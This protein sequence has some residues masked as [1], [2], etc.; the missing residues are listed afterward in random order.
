[1]FSSALIVFREAFEIVL[2]VGI[3]LA[4]TRTLPNR[5][6]WIQLGFA[7]GI[8]GAG[9]VAYFI[10]V[11]SN[12]AE[13]VGQELFSAAILFTAAG[14]IGWTF[15]WM[16]RHAREIKT[17]FTTLGQAINEG[18][19]PSYSLSIVIALAILREGAEI[20]LF[21]Y[22]MLANGAALS[23][24]LLGSL[25]GLAAGAVVGVLFYKG[26][27]KIS[28]KHFMTITGWM[29]AL[30]VCGM[31]SQGVGKLIA[32]G[33]L[34][35]LSETAWDSSWLLSDQSALGQTLLTLV[36]YTSSPAIAQVIAYIVTLALLIGLTRVNNK[37]SQS[38]T[39]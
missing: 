36:G 38:K 2:I 19:I 18:D 29:L 8:I 39:I 35:S 9:L 3:I 30:L 4:A 10:D 14:F 25:I 21:T 26:L 20:V 15:L 24:V 5:G 33:Y 22:G 32:S 31:M 34:I 17:Q 27:V 13:G 23:N 11:I 28:T 37:P 7:S 16:K 6:R 12:F 1:M